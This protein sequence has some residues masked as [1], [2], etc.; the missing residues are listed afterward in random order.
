MS[1]TE[2]SMKLWNPFKRRARREELAELARACEDTLRARHARHTQALEADIKT[3]R[4]VL[5]DKEGRARGAADDYARMFRR[6]SRELDTLREFR[7]ST[8][9]GEHK[10]ERAAACAATETPPL[11]PG[12]IR[13]SDRAEDFEPLWRMN[14]PQ[15]WPTL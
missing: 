12:T 7:R 1:H 13:V 3:L 14:E 6:M 5:H 8:L 2:K 11:P 4:G 10:A 9:E 15:P